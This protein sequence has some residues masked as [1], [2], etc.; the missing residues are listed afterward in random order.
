MLT[1]LLKHC[2]NP[3]I[4]GG[5]W[6]TPR[7]PKILL[8]AV[9]SLED[10]RAKMSQWIIRNGFGGGNLSNDCGHVMQDGKPIARLSYNGRAWE[11]G[12]WP[13]KEIKLRN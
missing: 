7:D 8:H 10:A 12:K 3:D 5:Y 1:L 13:T 6:E 2:P 9:S 4:A 11:P